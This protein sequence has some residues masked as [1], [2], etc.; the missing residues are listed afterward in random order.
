MSYPNLKNEDRTLLNVTTE[1]DEIRERKEKTERHE[2]EKN[3]KSLENDNEYYRKK[4][5]KS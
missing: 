3:L 4:Y 1:A 2:V 5:K